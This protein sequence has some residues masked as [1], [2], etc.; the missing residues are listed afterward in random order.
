MTRI[1]NSVWLLSGLLGALLLTGCIVVGTF[2]ID[3]KVDSNLIEQTSDGIYFFNVDLT[4]EEDWQDHQDKIKDIDNVGFLLKVTNLE[5]ADVGIEMYITQG[6]TE[7]FQT[8][9]DNLDD[10]RSNTTQVVRNLVIKGPSGTE[11]IID[12]PT[13]L[14]KVTNIATLKKYAES[15]KFGLYVVASEPDLKFNIDF[16]VV[17]VTLTAGN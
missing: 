14:S 15:G 5:D 10:I 1:K 6:L 16:A 17:I 11:T 4:T 7:D 3:Y 13:S 8:L 12:W 9:Y 2:V